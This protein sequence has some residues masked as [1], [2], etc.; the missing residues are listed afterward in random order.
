M[1]LVALAGPSANLLMALFWA[2]VLRL[3]VALDGTVSWVAKPLEYMGLAGII[4]NT[5]LMVLNLLP[6][7]PLDGG[8][9]L[10][11]VPPGPMAAKFAR[12]EP[13]GLLIL[14]LLLFTGVLGKILWPVI[15]FVVTALA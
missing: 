7:P 11:G 2:L 6:L 9:I 8:R 3:G 13:Y 15:V 14:L 5:I 4:I 12:I 1:A 10:T